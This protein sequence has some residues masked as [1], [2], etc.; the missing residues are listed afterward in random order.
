[1]DNQSENSPPPRDYADLHDYIRELD[2]AGLLRRI[3]EPINK[4]TELMPLVRWQFR[5]GVPEAD[6]KAWLF[7]N[8]TDAKGRAYDMPV[9]TAA[10]A[11][12][13]EM[14]AIGLGASTDQ[15]HDVWSHALTHPIPPR[16]VQEAPCQEVVV[17]GAE[18]DQPGQALD[19]LPAPIATPGW[20]NA[21]YLSAI[22]FI[23]KDP[24]TGLQN[25][26]T[27]RAQIK[28]PKT[29]G[30]NPSAQNRPGIYLHWLKYRERGEKMPAAFVIGAPMPVCY[31]AMWKVPE[32]LDELAVAGALTGQPVNVV[33][34]RTVDLLVPAEA[35]IVIEGYVDTEYL[36][37]EGPF[38]ESHGHV[39]LQEFNGVMEV[40]AITRRRD[41]VFLTYISQ[42]YPNEI[43]VVRAMVHE[44][45]FQR[46]LR[47]QLGVKGV[48]RVVTHQ[49][50]TGNR[51]VI[52]VVME[53]DVPRTEVWRALYGV[54]S[55]QRA[56]G[57]IVI[58]VN[59]DIEP[60]DLDSVLWAI[61]FRATPHLDMQ[62]LP[63]KDPGHG[64][65]T[66]VRAGTDSALLI[67]ATL[68]D[69]YPPV[70][71]PKREYMEH[72]RHIWEETLGLPPLKP[73]TPWF[74]Y[75]LGDWSDAME[76]EA[77]RAVNG[78]FWETGRINAQ[79]RRNDV[80]MNTD[81]ADVDEED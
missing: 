75:S 79:R 40:T 56:A 12:T 76:R 78:D 22:G 54:M 7:T 60:T 6:R 37:P 66:M 29:M 52:F 57:K 71:L 55:Q 24:D 41:A 3:D 38:G 77:A 46:F 1:M 23:S 36:E 21:P 48:I 62:I 73:E 45:G 53:R 68:K 35:E 72:A 15:A 67:D 51:K 33:K 30:M 49:P 61:A 65:A 16:V 63:H 27:Y 4:D 31:T 64:P 81:I 69:N 34:A 59:D 2:G 25:L 8:V 17:E 80:A 26:G 70:S 20:D 43:S 39:N 58:A 14:Y 9:L 28:T 42:L 74:G 44:H 13:R 47:E 19:S 32:S 10:I 50:L 18:L 11:S 5:G